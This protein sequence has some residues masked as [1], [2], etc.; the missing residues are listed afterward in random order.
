MTVLVSLGGR[1]VIYRRL[2]TCCA[3]VSGVQT[4]S[5]PI[6]K[7]QVSATAHP[8]GMIPLPMHILNIDGFSPVRAPV[9]D[10]STIDE[11]DDGFFRVRSSA[12]A[13]FSGKNGGDDE[14]R[15]GNG[16]PIGHGRL[17]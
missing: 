4:F 14:H 11:G 3:V 15:C 10:R 1:S 6:C 7:L 16:F 12:L 5:L 8:L 2:H 17:L 9:P 13:A